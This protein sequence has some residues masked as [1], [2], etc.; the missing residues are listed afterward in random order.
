[1]KETTKRT[2]AVYLRKIK[3][4]EEYHGAKV[5]AVYEGHGR[6]YYGPR[7]KFIHDGKERDY[8]ISTFN[9]HYLYKPCEN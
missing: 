1:M 8:S 3:I 7:V 6:N 5:L 4:G 9:K 2:Y